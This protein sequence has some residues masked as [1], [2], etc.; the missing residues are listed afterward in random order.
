MYTYCTVC[1][2]VLQILVHTIRIVDEWS[3][4]PPIHVN[5]MSVYTYVTHFGKRY[6]F[7]CQKLNID[8]LPSKESTKLALSNDAIVALVAA[9]VFA[10]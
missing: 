10:P 2:C 3:E 9:P 8:L 5:G 7:F 1:E 4:S 6:I